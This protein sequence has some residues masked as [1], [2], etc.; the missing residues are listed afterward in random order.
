MNSRN[1]FGH[2]DSTV[3]IVVVIII[4]IIIIIVLALTRVSIDA[5][6]CR[7]AGWTTCSRCSSVQFMCCEQALMYCCGELKWRFP[8]VHDKSQSPPEGTT[9]RLAVRPTDSVSVHI[10]SQQSRSRS[11]SLI[12]HAGVFYTVSRLMR[13]P[14]RFVFRD[15]LLHSLFHHKM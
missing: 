14:S 12:L 5:S 9:L 10:V 6:S 11:L 1:D 2:D 8:L 3:N 7:V 13:L 15:V 4:I